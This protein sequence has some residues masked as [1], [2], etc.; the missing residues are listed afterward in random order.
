LRQDVWAV[1]RGILFPKVYRARF[2]YLPPGSAG[3]K[4]ITMPE[5]DKPL[6]EDWVTIEDDFKVF[7]VSNVSHPA[8]NMHL[9]PMSKM[10][11]GLFHIVIVR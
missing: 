10:N 1:Y 7:W 5:F 4:T 11:D 3:K 8:Y 2:S 6:P 9:C